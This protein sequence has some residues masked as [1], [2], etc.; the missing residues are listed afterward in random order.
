MA[1]RR[2]SA[3][4]TGAATFG[5]IAFFALATR[6]SHGEAAVTMFST[7]LASA[8]IGHVIGDLLSKRLS[9]AQH[10]SYGSLLCFG[11]CLM[12]A[13]LGLLP[14]LTLEDR[15]RNYASP[16]SAVSFEVP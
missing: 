7:L 6:V 1:L 8:T 12:T 4:R 5:S 16:S 3:D 9:D 2:V 15:D 10:W 14:Y 13:T 11:G